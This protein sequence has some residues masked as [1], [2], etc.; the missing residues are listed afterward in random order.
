MFKMVF[1]FLWNSDSFFTCVVSTYNIKG[2]KII[3]LSDLVRTELVLFLVFI[4][5]I[6]VAVAFVVFLP[7]S[8][9]CV[10][11][12]LPGTRS[13]SGR[14]PM[15]TSA[16]RRPSR[17]NRRASTRHLSISHATAQHIIDAF[18]PGPKSSSFRRPIS[19]MNIASGLPLFY[20]LAKLISPDHE[21]IKD[22]TM[23]IKIVV[24]VN[25]L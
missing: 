11:P 9:L 23:F 7:V 14:S 15:W 6:S 3:K 25:D 5:N 10:D 13:Y 21:Y 18:R 17:A 19:E 22:N 12:W 2:I 4:S 24:D 1:C 16:S 8:R 20:S